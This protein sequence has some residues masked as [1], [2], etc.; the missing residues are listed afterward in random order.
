MEN[1]STRT[2]TAIG[3]VGLLLF[4]ASAIRWG[5]Q[6]EA[7]TPT[8]ASFS[9]EMPRP[10]N[11]EPG[12]DLSDRE[13]EHDFTKLPG[14]PAMKVAADKAKAKVDPKKAD[15]DKKAVAAKKAAQAKSRAAALAAA[16][17]RL[18][19]KTVNTARAAT[20]TAN[21]I[22]G[23]DSQ[24]AFYGDSGIAAGDNTTSPNDTTKKEEDEEQLTAS[25]W[26]S[27]LQSSPSAENIAKFIKAK[28]EGKIDSASYYQIVHELLVDSAL[29]R[30]RAALAILDQ[31]ISAKTFEFLVTSLASAPSDAKAQ[32]QKA[33]AS[34]AQPSKMALLVRVLASSKDA[35]V[36]QT[37]AAQLATAFSDFKK[38]YTSSENQNRR[39]AGGF[40]LQQFLAMVAPLKRL[41]ESGSSP[42]ASQ[43]SQLVS[44]IEALKSS[45]APAQASRL[46]MP[47]TDLY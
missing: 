11:Y 15:A 25:Q 18:D 40:S 45:S 43:M 1:I 17:R 22:P 10:Q 16:K 14:L 34:Y 9:Y 29:D 27:L 8:S 28:Q 4:L 47:G 44:E 12:F 41:A 30:R 38:V 7:W 24:T 33:L 37:A 2:W 31:D 26:R 6:R 23:S 20:L 32:I 36:L 39:L 46:A 35:A 3:V 21:F 19:V 5:V 42:V 13:V